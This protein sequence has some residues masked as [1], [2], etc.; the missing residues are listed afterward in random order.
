MQVLQGTLGAN[1]REL[2]RNVDLFAAGQFGV[3]ARGGRYVL[4]TLL[5]EYE[6]GMEMCRLEFDRNNFPTRAI[7]ASATVRGGGES[8]E[9]AMDE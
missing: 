2:E 9:L 7:R 6:A 3:S 5:I 4:D 8:D 1:F